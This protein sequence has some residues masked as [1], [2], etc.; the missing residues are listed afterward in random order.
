MTHIGKSASAALLVA[1]L[2]ATASIG[3]AQDRKG[4]QMTVGQEVTLTAC[5]EKAQKPDTFILTQVAD[6]PVHPATMGRV[7]Y[8][9]NDVKPLRPHV[10]HQIRVMGKIS[11]VKQGEMEIKAGDDGKGGLHVEIEGPGRDVRTAGAKAG[12]DTAGRQPNKDDIKTTLVRL[13]VSDVTMVAAS[14]PAK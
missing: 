9:L 2:I 4:N 12:V 14:C 13:N 7:V 8:W 5:V 3:A 11:E 10:G 6:M 1:G